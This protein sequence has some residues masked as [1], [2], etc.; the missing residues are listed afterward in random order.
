MKSAGSLN[1]MTDFGALSVLLYG[2][3]GFGEYR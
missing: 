2:E 1:F 3:M